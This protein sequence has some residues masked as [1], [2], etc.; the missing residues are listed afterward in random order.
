MWFKGGQYMVSIIAIYR[1]ARLEMSV[2]A[3]QAGEPFHIRQ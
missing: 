3:T 2:L 1:V